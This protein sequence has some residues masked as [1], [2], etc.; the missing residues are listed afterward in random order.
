[1]KLSD[2]SKQ[3]SKAEIQ[4]QIQSWYTQW[5]LVDRLYAAFAQRHGITSTAMF[6][7]RMLLIMPESCTQCEICNSLTLPKQT[8]SCLLESLE[9]SG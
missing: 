9:K 7:L 1:M 6:V 2:T 8:V 5:L 3:A 4:A